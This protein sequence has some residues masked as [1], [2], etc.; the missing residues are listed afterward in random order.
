M[1]R[2]TPAVSDVK[3]WAKAYDVDVGTGKPGRPESIHR[4]LSARV[5]SD[6]KPR[7]FYGSI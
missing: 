5:V 1:R 6:V 4:L 7:G 2:C 3:S